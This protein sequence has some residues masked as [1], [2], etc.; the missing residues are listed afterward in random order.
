[1]G[2]RFQLWFRADYLGNGPV[3]T[4]PRNMA[5]FGDKAMGFAG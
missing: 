1:M 4:R 2:R 5:L 3:L